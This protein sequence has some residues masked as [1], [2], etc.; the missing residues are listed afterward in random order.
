MIMN[1]LYL[2]IF[3]LISIT[4]IFSQN[5]K[6]EIK[7]DKNEYVYAE[8]ILIEIKTIN[9]DNVPIYID[10]ITF[11]YNHEGYGLY[12]IVTFSEGKDGVYQSLG[13]SNEEGNIDY[14]LLPGDSLFYRTDLNYWYLANGADFREL[15]KEGMGVHMAPGDYSIK[16]EQTLDGGK[17]YLSNTVDFSI[18]W[19]NEHEKEV[20]KEYDKIRGTNLSHEKLLAL[21]KKNPKTK[22]KSLILSKS[23]YLMNSRDTKKLYQ[24]LDYDQDGKL[25]EYFLLYPNFVVSV[26]DAYEIANDIRFREYFREKSILMKI[27]KNVSFNKKILKQVKEKN[28]NKKQNKGVK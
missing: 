15:R 7:L 17:K 27:L 25:F 10:N 26:L 20:Y 11:N 28:K 23:I 24:Y 2:I 13:F 18:K 5:L 21:Y 19:P 14:T 8:P 16:Y 1:K 22:Y 3:C 6:L 9:E 12:P 4:N